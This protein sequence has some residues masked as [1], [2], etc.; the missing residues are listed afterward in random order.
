MVTGHKGIAALLFKTGQIVFFIRRNAVVVEF[1]A[2]DDHVV[3]PD[4]HAAP[5]VMVD[6]VFADRD[7][8]TVF[9]LFQEHLPAVFVLFFLLYH[10]TDECRFLCGRKE[11]ENRHESHITEE[12]FIFVVKVNMVRPFLQ[13]GH[14]LRV[15]IA[16]HIE[17]G[18]RID[19]NEIAAEVTGTGDLLAFR[20][21][22]AF[23]PAHLIP[24]ANVR[25][26]T[27]GTGKTIPHKEG[28]IHFF[29]HNIRAVSAGC[30]PVGAF[31]GFFRLDLEGAVDLV[32]DQ[33]HIPDRGVTA[34]RHNDGFP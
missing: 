31:L 32:P 34:I 8:F 13:P 12:F 9:S 28:N 33:F 6:I 4:R 27:A 11:P 16:L 3:D 2:G 23:F 19:F 15:A 21:E 7:V 5:V 22:I 25:C 20:G 17:H 26:G 24:H 10:Q 29:H 30:D 18:F 14:P 1:I